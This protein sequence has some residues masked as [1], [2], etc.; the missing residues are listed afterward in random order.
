MESAAL[1][2]NSKIRSQAVVCIAHVTN[3]M[4]NVEGDFD[5]DEAAGSRY[6]L[7]II[8]LTGSKWMSAK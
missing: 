8:S 5:K 4:A 6:L 3:Q 2:A 7:R 1:Y